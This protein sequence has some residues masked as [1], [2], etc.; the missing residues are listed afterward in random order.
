MRSLQH[1][2]EWLGREYA[3]SVCTRDRDLGDTVPFRYIYSNVWCQSTHSRILYLRPANLFKE[4]ERASQDVRPDMIYLNSFFAPMSRHV[5]WLRRRGGLGAAP[6]LLAPRGEFNPGALALKRWKKAAYLWIA[7]ATGLCR[8]VTFHATNENEATEIRGQFGANA[9]V[10][11]AMNLG[12][13]T[14]P[15]NVHPP[16]KTVGGVKLVFLSRLVPKKNLHFLLPLLARVRGRIELVILGPKEDMAYVALLE[17]LV[18]ALPANIRVSFAGEVC[19][20]EVWRR[21][22]E[23]H[24]FVLPTLGENHGHAIVEAWQAGLP[25]LI[26]DRTPWRGLAEKHLGWDLPLESPDCWVATLQSCADMDE[27]TYEIRHRAAELHAQSLLENPPLD[28]WRQMFAQ[29]CP[30]A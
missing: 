22:A 2:T 12:P 29:V 3:F 28:D 18:S 11:T 10:F 19:G 17:N 5:L 23:A 24:F 13:K 9:R 21:L 25:V 20:D 27:E 1:L 16:R 15:E 8:G 7:R 6:L 14:I 26:S 4:L 30:T